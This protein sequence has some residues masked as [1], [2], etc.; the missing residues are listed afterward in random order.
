MICTL[1]IL[2][3]AAW[4]SEDLASSPEH[5]WAPLATGAPDVSAIDALLRRRLSPMGKGMLACAARVVGDQGPLRSVFASQHGDPARTLPVLEDLA[6]GLEASPT[7]FSM[8][9]HNA[10]AGIWSIARKDPSPSTSLAAGAETFGWGLVEACAQYQEDP[11]QPLLYVFGDDQLPDL[12]QRF[13]SRPT[14]LHAIA[15]LIGAGATMRLEVARDPEAAGPSSS[16]AQSMH[17]LL[18]ARAPWQGE[19]GAWSF[20]VTS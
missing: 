16:H 8:N 18:G 10:I 13:D 5:P 20:R 4:C 12:F 7:Q 1:P 19:R 9:V 14:P 15:L 6:R 2:R 3:A 11:S 17:A